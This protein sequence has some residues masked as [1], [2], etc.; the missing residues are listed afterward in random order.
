M[1]FSKNQKRKMERYGIIPRPLKSIAD[2]PSSVFVSL[3]WDEV[4]TARKRIFRKPCSRLQDRFQTPQR[5]P[6]K[7]LVIEV[8]KMLKDYN[9]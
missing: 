1:Y 7:T 6:R 9:P 2:Q 8:M 5:V 3:F 4:E